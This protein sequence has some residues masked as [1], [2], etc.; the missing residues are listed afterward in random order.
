MFTRKIP[1]VDRLLAKRLIDPVTGCW[2]F[3][4]AKAGKGYG[5][6]K[7]AG[8]RP[9]YAH[10]LSASI[11]M[12][13]DLSSEK[14]ILHHCDNPPCFNPEHLFEGTI[15]DNSLDAVQ[16][17]RAYIPT[18]VPMRGEQNP[19]VRISDR[20]VKEIVRLLGEGVYQK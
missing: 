15:R 6:M 9:E 16:K 13:F 4:G 19:M 20:D 3:T 8:E 5:Y 1:V 17:G 18:P 12:G 10:R 11:F 7:G 2:I 14:Q